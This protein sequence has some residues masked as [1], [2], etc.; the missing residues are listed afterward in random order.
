MD[1]LTIGIII[2]VVA[3]AVGIALS[4]F[5][6]DHILVKKKNKIVSE[7]KTEAEVIKKEKELAAKEKFLQLKLIGQKA[8]AYAG[9]CQ[10]I[11]EL[12]QSAL[13]AM[14]VSVSS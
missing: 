4:F 7:A 2:G 3:F 13:S 11:T 1:T 9:L 5:L 8:N 6:W 14:Y 12:Y 10:I